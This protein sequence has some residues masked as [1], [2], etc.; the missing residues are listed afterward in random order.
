LQHER[1][2]EWIWHYWYTQS[3]R[4]TTLQNSFCTT[5]PLDNDVASKL[6]Q[7]AAL[8]TDQVSPALLPLC[9]APVTAD[10]VFVSVVVQC[11]RLYNELSAAKCDVSSLSTLNLLRKDYKEFALGGGGRFVVGMSSLPQSLAHVAQRSDLA[12]AVREMTSVYA[13]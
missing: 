10:S 8:D 2:S 9:S 13:S 4:Q 12:Q 1:L 7:M 3:T 5:A 11:T 6:S